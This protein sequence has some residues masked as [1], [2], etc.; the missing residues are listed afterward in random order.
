MKNYTVII[1]LVVLLLLVGQ[2]SAQ[3][4]ASATAN[5]SA[6][7]DQAKAEAAE[8]TDC[9]TFKSS[10]V[11]LLDAP[12]RKLGFE[13]T[14]FEQHAMDKNGNVSDQKSWKAQV[15]IYSYGKSLQY[16]AARE[17]SPFVEKEQVR[18]IVD[19]SKDL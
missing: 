18:F 19:G 16:L 2:I 5:V 13:M 9:K 4:A 17:S 14:I 8:C 3:N 12:E 1:S 11:F 7:S 6:A 10:R 15:N